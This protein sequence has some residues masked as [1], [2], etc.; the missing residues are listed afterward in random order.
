MQ[1]A[2]VKDTHTSA[3]AYARTYTHRHSYTRTH[4]QTHKHMHTSGA[5]TQPATGK[6]CDTYEKII[7][8]KLPKLMNFYCQ[9]HC[10]LLTPVRPA[11]ALSWQ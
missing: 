4:T 7:F 3:Y 11:E 6:F 8:S 1:N 10:T 2:A 9:L 5:R